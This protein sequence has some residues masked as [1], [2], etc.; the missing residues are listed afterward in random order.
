M[1]F[2]KNEL[3]L[4]LTGSAT[5]TAALALTFGL[6]IRTIC[7]TDASARTVPP[8]PSRRPVE[9][10]MNT[11]GVSR[12]IVSVNAVV[13]VVM[14]GKATSVGAAGDHSGMA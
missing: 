14:V 10:I 1:P 3:P 9:R 5:V 2:T 11:L 6:A 4:K 13:P 7:D 8:V 12:R